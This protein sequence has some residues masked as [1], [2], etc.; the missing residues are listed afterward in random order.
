M[1]LTS[2]VTMYFYIFHYIHGIEIKTVKT[3]HD[4]I[5]KLIYCFMKV[6]RYKIIKTLKIRL[7][8]KYRTT[9]TPSMDVYW[10]EQWQFYQNN[11]YNTNLKI[12]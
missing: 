3:L 12:Y 10:F 6:N 4:K 7:N 8:I 11:K 5:Y 2:Y 1:L 9:N